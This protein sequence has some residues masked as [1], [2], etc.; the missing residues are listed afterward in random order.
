MKF[1]LI[2]AEKDHHDVSLLAR[3]LGVSR[4]GYY[5][6]TRRQRHGPSP[7]ARHDAMLTK[8]IRAHHTASDEIYGAPRIHADLRE[9]DHIRVGRKRVARLMRAAGLAGVSRR[10]GCRT[11]VAD[12]KAAAA[13]DLVKR[14]F[15][16]AEPNRL[17]TADITY[18][19]TWQGFLYLAVVLDV[20][21]RRIVGWAMADHMRT[22]LVSDALAMAIHQRRPSA[23]VI[24]HSD[25]GSQ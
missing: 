22:E 12:R 6:W 21:S 20:F 11:T 2:H 16:A 1:R 25:K 10:K 17:W 19:P 5:A 15:T 3:V 24:H 4:Q 8:K 23:G 18:V 14:N 7:R 9:I 13:G